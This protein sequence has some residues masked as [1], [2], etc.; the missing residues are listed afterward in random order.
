MIVINVQVT[1]GELVKKYICPKKLY[2][3]INKYTMYNGSFVGHR[4]D[5]RAI[6]IH[7]QL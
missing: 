4:F 3:I 6:N 5:Y 1:G 2:D 7:C